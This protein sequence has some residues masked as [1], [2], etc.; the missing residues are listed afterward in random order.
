MEEQ[1]KDYSKNKTEVKDCISN[2]GII[3][4]GMGV[5]MS[6]AKKQTELLEKIQRFMFFMEKR[7]QE[8]FEWMKENK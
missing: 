6:H 2:N 5:L 4:D 7:Q 8:M 1:K 3:V